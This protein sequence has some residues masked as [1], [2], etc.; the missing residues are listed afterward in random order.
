M[1]STHSQNRDF[2]VLATI[3][4]DEIGSLHYGQPS[5]IYA[6][7]VWRPMP[8]KSVCSRTRIGVLYYMDMSPI[9]RP[10]QGNL[11]IS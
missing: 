7:T 4:S 8:L 2:S 9:N 3:P 10:W 1:G 5:V 6:Y 11:V